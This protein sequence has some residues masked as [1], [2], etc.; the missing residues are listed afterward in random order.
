MTPMPTQAR[1]AGAPAA[2]GASQ[3]PAGNGA[4]AEPGD[5]PQQQ[6]RAPP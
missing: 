4:E 3:E 5:A 1:R 2:P 6:Q